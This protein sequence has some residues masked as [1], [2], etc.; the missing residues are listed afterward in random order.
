MSKNT[1]SRPKARAA[2]KENLQQLETVLEKERAALIEGNAR[3]VAELAVEKERIAVLLADQSKNDDD[4]A[5]SSE[6]AALA[7]S[8]SDLAKLNH[9]LLGQ[10]YQHYHG[11]L[12]LFMRIAGQDTTYGP[13]GMM[14]MSR[15]SLKDTEI[16]A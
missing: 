12:E 10:M 2:L 13:D 7:Q 15:K 4:Q 6:L 11:M 8:V 9:T 3:M 1:K 14:S 5:H 16:L